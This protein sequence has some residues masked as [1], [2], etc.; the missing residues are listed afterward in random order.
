MMEITSLG[1]VKVSSV[2]EAETITSPSLLHT[3]WG[4]GQAV[5]V[6]WSL[7]EPSNLATS[8]VGE[9][10][11]KVGQGKERA[12]EVRRDWRCRRRQSQLQGL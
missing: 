8:T 5:V 7:E 3:G 12:K 10:R 6:H 1:M 4:L 2:S 11:S 9:Q